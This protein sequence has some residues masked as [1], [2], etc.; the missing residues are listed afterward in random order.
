MTDKKGIQQQRFESPV[1]TPP[2][3]MV[4]TRHINF[5]KGTSPGFVAVYTFF[6]CKG[7]SSYITRV[8]LQQ[9]QEW[10]FSVCNFLLFIYHQHCFKGNQTMFPS[11]AL[12]KLHQC[13]TYNCNPYK[14]KYC[15]CTS[16][17]SSVLHA[18]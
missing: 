4:N 5:T 14:Y 16:L 6:I 15:A 13:R 11:L 12:F 2:G 3:M 9:L 7:N 10:S 1:V 17:V 18:D 8:R